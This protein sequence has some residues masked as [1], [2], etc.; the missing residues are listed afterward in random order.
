MKK[1]F[2]SICIFLASSV[3]ADD[4][5]AR[6]HDY[7]AAIVEVE[8]EIDS[9]EA[10]DLSLVPFENEIES[11]AKKHNLEPALLAAFIQEESNFDAWAYRYEPGFA[12]RYKSRIYA[13]A[14]AWSRSHKGL[15]TFQSESVMRSTSFG[16]M[17]PMG[18]VAREEGFK[19]RYL[20]ELIKPFN[21]IEAGAKHLLSKMKKYPKDTLSA[22]SA[23]NQGDNRKKNGVFENARYVYRVA[24]AWNEYRKIFI[25]R[26]AYEEQLKNILD[27]RGQFQLGG[28]DPWSFDSRMLGNRAIERGLA[29]KLRERTLTASGLRGANDSDTAASYYRQG[30]SE[31]KS[32]VLTA[33]YEREAGYSFLLIGAGLLSLLGLTWLF[34]KGHNAD[35]SGYDNG[36]PQHVD[37]RTQSFLRNEFAKKRHRDK[38]HRM[39][40]AGGI[41]QDHRN[42]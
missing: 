31:P 11:V 18:Q 8:R 42:D 17:Q 4:T 20:I 15:P 37:E 9:S 26:K 23:Y 19:A 30:Y 13:E 28:I 41:P 12:K 39:G 5:T 29:Y 2:I 35:L 25:S 6:V 32:Q 40:Y 14:R 24:V 21:S 36:V 27:S 1:I 38:V 22:I 7:V 34:R 16:L 10:A 3:R 33:G